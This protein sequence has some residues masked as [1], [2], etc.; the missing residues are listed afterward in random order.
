MMTS[1]GII[2]IAINIMETEFVGKKAT[3][4]NERPA[5]FCGFDHRHRL[6]G[7]GPSINL[8]L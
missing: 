6:F 4:S 7:L 3:M 5:G 1:M 8:L 2:T